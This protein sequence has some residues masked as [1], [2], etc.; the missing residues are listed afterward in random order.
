LNSLL[1]DVKL[2]PHYKDIWL[3]ILSEIASVN[4]GNHTKPKNAIS[5]EDAKILLLN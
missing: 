4:C 5:G 3:T 2:R 1:T